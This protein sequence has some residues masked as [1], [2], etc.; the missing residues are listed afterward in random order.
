MHVVIVCVASG[1]GAFALVPNE[2]GAVM[3]LVGGFFVQ[4]GLAVFT[5]LLAMHGMRSI[6]VLCPLLVAKYA[7]QAALF[8]TATNY[9]PYAAA[10]VFYIFSVLSSI[11][12][13]VLTGFR[14]S[15]LSDVSRS[16]HLPKA[17]PIVA[18]IIATLSAALSLAAL[19]LNTLWSLQ[20]A[21]A[22]FDS[23]LFVVAPFGII[24]CHICRPVALEQSGVL[25]LPALFDTVGSFCGMV[26]AFA[27]MSD[28]LS[29]SAEQTWRILVSVGNLTA[30]AAA[31]VLLIYAI[32]VRRRA[33][34]EMRHA[35]HHP[36]HQNIQAGPQPV[37]PYQQAPPYQPVDP[38]G[39]AAAGGSG[40]YQLRSSYGTVPLKA[41][42]LPAAHTGVTPGVSFAYSDQLE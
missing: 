26:G 21:I 5:A 19:S 13:A 7:M 20:I 16:L 28:E 1:L 10:M 23:V 39:G 29:S 27:V 22:V 6:F 38:A 30:L 42:N 18:A 32:V 3:K 14:H 35:Q 2:W 31:A 17:A 40:S 25:L 4:V 37:P 15:D 24:M 34:H 33:R 36:L 12:C 9:P 41:G 11:L 8:A